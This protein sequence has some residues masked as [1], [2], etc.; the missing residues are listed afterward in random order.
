MLLGPLS[1]RVEVTILNILG[2]LVSLRAPR[3]AQMQIAAPEDMASSSAP[4]APLSEAT[5]NSVAAAFNAWKA[6]TFFSAWKVGLLISLGN[7]FACVR[8]VPEP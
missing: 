1:L 5:Q 7:I 4:A 6:E 2:S 3:A 8:F